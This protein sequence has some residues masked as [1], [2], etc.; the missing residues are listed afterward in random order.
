MKT[1]QIENT[2]HFVEEFVVHHQLIVNINRFVSGHSQF[3]SSFN[4]ISFIWLQWGSIFRIL[5]HDIFH[6]NPLS[7]TSPV[8]SIPHCY[9]V[10]SS[11]TAFP[12]AFA[13][14]PSN[15]ARIR[16]TGVLP[17]A[18]NYWLLCGYFQS[19]ENTTIKNISR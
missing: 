8:W 12:L 11:S 5:Q 4:Y 1:I 6:Y 2:G 15:R 3:R 13:A 19:L 9:I 14:I 7:K 10:G 16:P 18:N 17:Q